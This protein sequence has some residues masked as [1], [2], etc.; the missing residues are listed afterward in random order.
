MPTGH[1]SHY[2]S[3]DPVEPWFIIH[4]QINE[5]GMK[6]ETGHWAAVE[7][8]AMWFCLSGNVGR[9]SPEN[10]IHQ[11]DCAAATIALVQPVSV[12]WLQEEE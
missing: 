10:H 8:K 11:T 12:K 2:C 5:D 1:V 7:R 9:I 6:R 3:A 4:C